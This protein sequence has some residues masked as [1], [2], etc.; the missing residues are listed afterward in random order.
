MT[1][2]VRWEPF[3]ELAGL[4]NRMDRLFD[5]SFGGLLERREGIRP[6][7]MPTIDVFEE[8][9]EI[10]LRAELPGMTE[11]DV[12][13][14]IEN[15]NLVLKGEKMQ[16]HKEEKENGH[17]RQVESYYGSFYRS[18]PM[19]AGVDPKKIDAKMKDGVLHVALPKSE[20]AKPKPIKIKAS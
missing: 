13:I 9:S 18:F 6:E 10:E 16:E 12:S 11:K 17:Y 8:D 2:L 5:E 20:V 15:G 4:R 7:W 14:T 3:R 1:Q 19:P